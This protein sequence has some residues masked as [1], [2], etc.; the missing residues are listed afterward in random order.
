MRS[1]EL[2]SFE[3]GHA[4]RAHGAE[5]TRPCHHDGPVAW[6]RIAGETARLATEQSDELERAANSCERCWAKSL[7]AVTE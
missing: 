4:R 1:E 7:N 3:G 6:P 5:A 2:T